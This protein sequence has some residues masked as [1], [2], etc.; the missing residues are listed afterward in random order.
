MATIRF[1][2]EVHRLAGR[3]PSEG[4]N[5]RRADPRP[6]CSPHT[7]IS[8]TLWQVE[9]KA[10]EPGDD[11]IFPRNLTARAAYR[12]AGN[13]DTTRPEDSVSN[14]YPGLDTDVRNLDRRFFPG[15]V[16]EF[17]ARRDTDRPYTEPMRYGALLAY[18]DHWGDPDLQPQYLLTLPD[19][20]RKE[21][22]D[23]STDLLKM[24][25]GAQGDALR[26]NEWYLDWIEQHGKRITMDRLDTTPA[27]PLDGLF[28]WRLVRGL[29]PGPVT[30]GLVRRDTRET[31][32][33]KGW[34]RRFTH[35]VTGVLSGAYQA[36]ELL[37]S[38]CSP[39]QHDFRDCSCH[40]WAT[41]RPDVVFGA[42]ERGDTQD[43]NV[44]ATQQANML[45]DWI[46]ADRSR[47]RSGA[48]FKEMPLN[49]PYQMDHFEINRTWKELNI[50]IN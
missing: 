19:N 4:R 33:L 35:P 10:M 6:Y 23:L 16:F 8:G 27:T 21:I 20:V 25:R 34:R 17:V 5:G 28:V 9:V 29:E 49:R 11:K 42:V 14:C 3:T 22:Q 46:R 41:N 37:Q 24:L 32:V 36:G 2:D 13:P 39:W 38:L 44:E 48:A 18:V 7:R 15:L 30:I 50:V 12:V 45:L 40:Y 47:A 31:M 43:G 26:K 1:P